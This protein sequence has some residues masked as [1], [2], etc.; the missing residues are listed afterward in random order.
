MVRMLGAFRSPRVP[1]VSASV[2]LLLLTFVQCGDDDDGG[3]TPGVPCHC[4]TARGCI[5]DCPESGCIPECD[6]VDFCSADCGSDCDYTCNNVNQCSVECG[7]DCSVTCHDVSECIAEVGSGSCV[8]CDRLS[9]CDV[10]CHGDCEVRCANVP[11]SSCVA[12][13]A[14]G[15]EPLDCGNG[16]LVCNTTCPSAGNSL[17]QD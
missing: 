17:C 8:R 13:C 12:R 2:L 14:S 1:A 11:E 7:G 16:V 15:D 6:N 4:S 3:C 9:T 5:Y 10:Y